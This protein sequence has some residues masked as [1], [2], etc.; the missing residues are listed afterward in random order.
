MNGP[1]VPRLEGTPLCLYQ[2]HVGFANCAADETD[3]EPALSASDVLGKA[4]RQGVEGTA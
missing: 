2:E 4:G 3:P 1:R